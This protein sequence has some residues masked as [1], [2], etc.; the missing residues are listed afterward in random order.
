M[1]NFNKG[2][3]TTIFYINLFIPEFILKIKINQYDIVI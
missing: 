3:I 1:G 2:N